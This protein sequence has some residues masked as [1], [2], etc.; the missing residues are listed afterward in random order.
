MHIRAVRTVSFNTNIVYIYKN[1]YIPVNDILLAFMETFVR[2]NVFTQP[3][4]DEKNVGLS[5]K[6]SFISPLLLTA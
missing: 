6:S 1:S 3:A 5:D 4:Y 2:G